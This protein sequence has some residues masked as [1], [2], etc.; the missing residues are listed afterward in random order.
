MKKLSF[1]DI[2]NPTYYDVME[3]FANLF[4]KETYD[5]IHNAFSEH[6][7]ARELEVIKEHSL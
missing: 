7:N 3:I 6:V 1:K 2:E 4:N 5:K